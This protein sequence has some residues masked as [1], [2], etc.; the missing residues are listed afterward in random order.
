MK[1]KWVLWTLV[2]SL[3]VTAC[4]KQKT[5]PQIPSSE[6]LIAITDEQEDS[7]FSEADTLLLDDELTEA[8]LPA[9]VDEAF[10][11]FLFLFDNSNRFQ[12]QRV[13]Y[14][15]AVTDVSGEHHVIER[16][17]WTYHSMTL[18][19]DFC[20][21]LWNNHKQI[22]LSNEMLQ[23]ARV[24]HIYLHS[25]IVEVFDFKRDSLSGQWMLTSQR[26]IPFDRYELANFMDFY[27][28][29]ATDSIFQRHHVQAP[30]RFTMTSEDSEE[31]IVEGTIDVDQWFEFAPEI[32]KAVLVNINYGQ[33]YPNPNR[34]IMQMRG[35][36]DS[37]QNLLVYQKD[38]NGKWRL[39]EFE[40]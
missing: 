35:F 25:R 11:D 29:F 13:C 12:R 28:E 20:T 16:H 4:L 5:G 26:S 3:V 6:A 31:D 1:Q 22:D 27:S 40:N 18:G 7:L 38:Y 21:V 37:M 14:P 24:E 15:L 36:N 32:P 39:T 2:G 19:Q 17:E 23:E 8:P 10:D 33:Q 34:I 9:T 30:L